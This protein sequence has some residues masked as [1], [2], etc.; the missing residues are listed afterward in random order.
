MTAADGQSGL[1]GISRLRPDVAVVDIGLPRLDG[2]EVA[3]RVRSE[4]W[5]SRIKLIALTGYGRAEDR[6]AVMQAGFDAHLVKPV[7]PTELVRV[8][9]Q[10]T[11]NK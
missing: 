3:R 7:N 2:Y 4:R 5:G 1:D 8:I 9:A 6:V 10:A 11:S